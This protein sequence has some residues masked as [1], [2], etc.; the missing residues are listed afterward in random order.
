MIITPVNNHNAVLYVL[1]I[2][3]MVKPIGSRLK[4]RD[5][6]FSVS[7]CLIRKVDNAVSK[8]PFSYAES[9]WMTILV[10]GSEKARMLCI[11]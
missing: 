6:V 8:P 1:R 9:L 2:A 4:F 3:L 7:G 10:R 5:A 11:K